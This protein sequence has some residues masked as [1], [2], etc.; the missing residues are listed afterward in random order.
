MLIRYISVCAAVVIAIVWW[1]S[2]T[3]APLEDRSPSLDSV[4]SEHSNE[5][6]TLPNDYVRA[7]QSGSK[8]VGLTGHAGSPLSNQPLCMS[9]EMSESEKMIFEAWASTDSETEARNKINSFSNLYEAKASILGMEDGAQKRY[10]L[11]VLL[12]ECVGTAESFGDDV[13]STRSQMRICWGLVN[14]KT[15]QLRTQAYWLLREATS[16]GHLP[17]ALKIAE[18]QSPDINSDSPSVRQQTAQVIVDST[19]EA[20]YAAEALASKAELHPLELERL[21][22]I[23]IK[24]ASYRAILGEHEDSVEDHNT[25]LALVVA[26][27]SHFP[28]G[29]VPSSTTCDYIAENLLHQSASFAVEIDSMAMKALKRYELREF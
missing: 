9:A 28:T 16:L 22:E 12:D 1:G 23:K 19:E 14:D 10:E 4:T 3:T 25:G 6:I 27:R 21:G 8:D 2:R 24:Q 17:S 29:I 13:E 7:I 15:K 26:A 11:A 5:G 20:F 18:F